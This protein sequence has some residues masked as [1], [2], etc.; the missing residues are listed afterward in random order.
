[1]RISFRLMAMAGLLL[2][3]FVATSAA[4]PA[5]GARRP[6]AAR[7]PLPWIEN[8]WPKALSLARARKV[9]ILVENWAPW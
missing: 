3:A 5:R 7:G 4:A 6:P 1:M 9:P 8:D 2:A